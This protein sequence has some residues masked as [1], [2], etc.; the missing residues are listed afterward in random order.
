MNGFRRY[1]DIENHYQN[2]YIHGWITNNTALEQYKYKMLNMDFDEDK[3]EKFIISSKIHGT[4]F[5]IYIDDVN[6]IYGNRSGPLSPN[7]NF[8][9]YQSVVE[10]DE[11]QDLIG[12]LKKDFELPIII[13]GEMYGTGIQKEV[14]YGPKKLRFFDIWDVNKQV[15]IDPIRVVEWFLNYNKDL[16]VPIIKIDA[17]LEEA[18]KWPNVFQSLLTPEGYDKS[19]EE[20]GIVIKPQ[21]EISFTDKDGHYSRFVIKSKNPK[22][23]EKKDV[24]KKEYVINKTIEPFLNIAICFLNENRAANVMSKFE[25]PVNMAPF[26]NMIKEFIKDYQKD[27][28]KDNPEFLELSQENQKQLYNYCNNRAATILKKVFMEILNKNKI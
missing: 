25:E 14:Y 20:E 2:K 3:L 9:N 5:Q 8:F 19:N 24:V 11:I 10:T 22:F 6:T 4:N 28:E 26:G 12:E 13:F 1:P 7:S 21:H 17:T 27:F 16:L 15:M 18:L 23:S